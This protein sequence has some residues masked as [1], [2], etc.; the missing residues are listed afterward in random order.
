VVDIFA[1]CSEDEGEERRGEGLFL[2]RRK[3]HGT[4]EDLPHK[5]VNRILH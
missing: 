5:T 2:F 1:L 4:R 3:Q